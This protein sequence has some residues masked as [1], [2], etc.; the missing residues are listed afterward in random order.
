MIAML[1]LL[2]WEAAA[3]A[4]VWSCFCR[5]AYTHKGNTRRDVRW[6]FQGL[7]VLAVICLAAPLYGY[8]PDGMA[9]ALLVWVAI[10]QIVTAHHWR[11]G[12]PKQF[13]RS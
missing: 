9:I 10:M 11:A 7:G 12:V 2:G 4:L 5:A 3:A 8:E 6:A 13:R 1:V